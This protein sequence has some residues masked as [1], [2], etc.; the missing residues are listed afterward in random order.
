MTSAIIAGLLAAPAAFAR[1]VDPGELSTP[2]VQA[3][4]DLNNSRCVLGSEDSRCFAGR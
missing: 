1:H 2:V 4:A 3:R